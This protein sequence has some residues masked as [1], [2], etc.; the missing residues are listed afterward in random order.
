[1]TYALTVYVCHSC[2]NLFHKVFYVF[3]RNR[4]VSFFSH[5]DHF[6]QVL[7]TVLENNVLNS[8]AFVIL[9]V[10]YIQ[11]LDTVVAV[12]KFFKYFELS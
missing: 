5:L 7:V 8:L 6:F 3:H 11:H 2:Q 4:T 9:A 10:V 1:M 12:P